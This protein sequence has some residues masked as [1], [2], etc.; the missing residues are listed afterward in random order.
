[1]GDNGINLASSLNRERMPRIFSL[2]DNPFHT[3]KATY[4]STV[5]DI[6]HLVEDAE[7]DGIFPE[8]ELQKAR[9]ALVTPRTRLKHELTWLPELSQL[10]A[11]KLFEL[12]RK[13]DPAT[14]LSLIDPFP[15]RVN[16][17][18]TVGF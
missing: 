18:E 17:F 14:V 3:L 2:E 1:M 6:S 11:A 8:D 7:M 16:D 12:L 13:P 9:Q 15:E 4:R 10:Q 5:T